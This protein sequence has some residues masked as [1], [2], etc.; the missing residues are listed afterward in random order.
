MKGSLNEYLNY[1]YVPSPHSIYSGVFKLIPGSYLI[2]DTHNKYRKPAKYWD[3]F[4]V[5]KKARQNQFKGDDDEAVKIL[6]KSGRIGEEF[7]IAPMRIRPAK[8]SLI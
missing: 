8:F 7:G 4:D 6:E 2:I 5:A 1:G 3:L